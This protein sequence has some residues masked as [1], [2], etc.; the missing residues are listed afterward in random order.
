LCT[1]KISIVLVGAERWCIAFV[2][3]SIILSWQWE[4]DDRRGKSYQISHSVIPQMTFGGSNTSCFVFVSKW[5]CIMASY[6]RFKPTRHWKCG[7]RWHDDLPFILDC[8][9]D[10]L[11]FY[12]VSS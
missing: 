1:M 6:K 7:W 9:C 8:F 3:G 10:N 11:D 5:K 2:H 4:G 12:Q